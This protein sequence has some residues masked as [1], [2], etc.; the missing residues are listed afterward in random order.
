M[1]VVADVRNT[2]RNRDDTECSSAARSGAPA[3]S[4]RRRKLINTIESLTTTPDKQKNA[5][6]DIAPMSSP[7]IQWPR[8]A[9]VNP[10]GIAVMIAS[11]QTY[12]ENAHAR[13]R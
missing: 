3:S 5:S 2:A 4:S 10:N 7:Q 9:P 13:I 8:I 11:G 1:L 6:N 12:D